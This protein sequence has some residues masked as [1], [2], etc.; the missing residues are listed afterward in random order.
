MRR[1]SS[2]CASASCR[3]LALSVALVCRAAFVSS[4]ARSRRS[5]SS[6][7][8]WKA[9][10]SSSAARPQR[11][12]GLLDTPRLAQ[13]GRE[14][15]EDQATG[16]GDPV[17][18]PL[19][20]SLADAARVVEPAECHP[21]L[22]VGAHR[23]AEHVR[24]GLLRGGQQLEREL[25]VGER[26]LGPSQEQP[27]VGAGGVDHAQRE[28]VRG[29]DPVRRR[30]CPCELGLSLRELAVGLHVAREVVAGDRL[31]PGVAA[32]D[33]ELEQ[34]LDTAPQ[35]GDA[36]VPEH[37]ARRP[38][39]VDA[40]PEVLRRIG[41][42]DGTLGLV[43]RLRVGAGEEAELRAQRGDLGVRGRVRRGVCVALG[44]HRPAQRP[45]QVA[46]VQRDHAL[47]RARARTQ[48]LVGSLG[49]DLVAAH[50]DGERARRILVVA[51]ARLGQRDPC[52]IEVDRRGKGH[53]DDSAERAAN[54]TQAGAPPLS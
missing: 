6:A 33:R 16:L 13:A 41:A 8:S 35:V 17:P 11:V 46:A 19:Q 34:L 52:P 5:C 37:G 38:P 20:R 32:P 53:G 26:L 22:H 4:V 12:V 50:R 29:R 31:L 7:S 42:L 51:A 39:R 24:V 43:E 2:A 14:R 15:G 1:S 3:F 54:L 23:R 21:C 18:Q 36:D 44:L 48:L 28:A 49:A 47:E 40:Q 45:A 30:K 9:W 27:Q 10:R 25:G